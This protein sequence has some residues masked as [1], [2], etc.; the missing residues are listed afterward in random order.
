M[1][2]TID[3]PRVAELLVA[4][5]VGRDLGPLARFDVTGIDHPARFTCAEGDR[6]AIAVDGT[7]VAT[8]T[9]DAEG[10]EVRIRTTDSRFRVEAG[11]TVKPA[12]DELVQRLA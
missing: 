3:G 8:L 9:V 11:S 4:E 6:F 2:G 10:A 7:N 1:M 5:L 12:I